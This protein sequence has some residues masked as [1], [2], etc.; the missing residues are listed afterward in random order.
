MAGAKMVRA[1]RSFAAVHGKVEYFIREGELVPTTHPVAKAH[2]ELFGPPL[3]L[4][5]SGAGRGEKRR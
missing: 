3:P 1:D 5:A 2:P 4:E